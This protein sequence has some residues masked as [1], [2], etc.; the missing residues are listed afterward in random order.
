MANKFRGEA[1]LVYDRETDEGPRATTKKLSFDANA[2]CEIEEATGSNLGEMLE[3]LS[4]PKKMSMRMLRGIVYGGIQRHHPTPNLQEGL[5]IAGDIISDAGMQETIEA[6][7]K[8]VT[9]AMAK[10]KGKAKGKAPAKP[11]T[12]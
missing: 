4:D 10:Q 3:V 2:F 9:G 5:V 11:A 8:A 6:I 12:A 1:E 7:H